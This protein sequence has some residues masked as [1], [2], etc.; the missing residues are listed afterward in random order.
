MNRPP[1]GYEP[2]KFTATRKNNIFNN[3]AE[4]VNKN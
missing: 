2:I 3:F 1:K 4:N